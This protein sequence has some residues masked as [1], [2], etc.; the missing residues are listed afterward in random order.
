MNTDIA[1]VMHM[2]LGLFSVA[3]LVVVIRAA[4]TLSERLT[5]VDSRLELLSVLPEK[6][7]EL[8]KRM[9]KVE[10]DLNALFSKLRE[11][12]VITSHEGMRRI[13]EDEV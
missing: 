12:N 5:K 7:A 11:S 4:W 3:N 13:H 9:F 8:D 1:T 10:Y 6:V 2:V